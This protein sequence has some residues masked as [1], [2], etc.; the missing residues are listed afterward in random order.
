MNMRIF[1]YLD[2][3]T[4]NFEYFKQKNINHI[5]AAVTGGKPKR[6]VAKKSAPKRKAGAGVVAG[7]KKKRKVAKKKPVKK[8]AAKKSKKK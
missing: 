7:G 1:S 5:M 2:E 4:T 6:K 3:Y 8:K